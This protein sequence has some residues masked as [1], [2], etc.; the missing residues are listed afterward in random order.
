MTQNTTSNQYKMYQQQENKDEMKRQVIS[1]VMMIVF[2]IVAFIAVASGAAAMFVI[3]L[4]FLLAVIQAAFQFFYFM[5]M[6]DKGHA[7][8]SGA[9]Y[10]G[11]LVTFLTILALGVI[12]WW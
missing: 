1:F 11:T 9:I 7:E 8:A 10:G 5:H 2:T 4:I 6:K 3:P 12:T